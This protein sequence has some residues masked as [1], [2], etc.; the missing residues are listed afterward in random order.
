MD[1]IAQAPR[2]ERAELFRRSAPALRPARPPAIMEKDFWVCWTLH[3]IYDVLQFRPQMIFK[4]G[5]S[6]SKAYDAIARFLEDVDLSLSR[7]DLGFADDRDPEE[8]GISRKESGRRIGDLVAACRKVIRDRL[9]PELRAD[10]TSVLGDLDWNLE[11]DATDLQTVI[12]TYPRSDMKSRLPEH[13]RPAIRLEMGARSDDW[14]AEDREVRPYAAE[15]FPQAFKVAASCRAHV[16]NARRTFW[17]KA[18]L[19][20]AE[21]HRPTDKPA[22]QGISRHYYDLYQLSHHDIGRQALNHRDLLDRVVEHKRLFFASAWAHYETATAANFHLVPPEE[23]MPLLRTDYARM[24][25]MVFGEAPAWEWIVQ[26]L[27]ELE[28]RING[29]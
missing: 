5:T 19:L 18:T 22:A 13:I 2:E 1:G 6:L 8:P 11:L 4:G 20:H 25:E 21:F 7:R 24:R 10:F 3:R 27:R 14:P 17:E 16:L 23:R 26:G 28:D 29:K 15:V 12:F 9:L